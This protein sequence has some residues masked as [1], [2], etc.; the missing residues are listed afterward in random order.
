MNGI[1]LAMIDPSPLLNALAIPF[2]VAIFLIV[3]LVAHVVNVLILISP[4]GIV[5]AALKSARLLVLSTLTAASLANPYLG[6]A[7]SIL[8]II[9]CYFL[10]GWA[11]RMTLFGAVFAWDL[12]TVRQKRFKPN[13]TANR[14]F[15]AR[16]MENA[17]VRTYGKLSRNEQGR[18]VLRYRPWL[19]LPARLLVLPEGQYVIGRGLFYPELLQIEGNCSKVILDFPPRSRTHEIEL[20]AIYKLP[21]VQDTGVIKGFKAVWRWIKQLLGFS[22]R[23]ASS[24]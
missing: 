7:L 14:I 9:I 16:A 15:T 6:A 5:D 24:Q 18:L 2:A 10:A 20:S 11:F 21:E 22:V 1:V 8:L 12:L 13:P 19:L 4:F 23:V 3:W 17:P